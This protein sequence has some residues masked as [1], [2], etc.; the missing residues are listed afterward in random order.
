MIYYTYKITNKVN[1]KFYIGVHKTTDLDDGYMGSGKLLTQAIKKY[2]IENF[3]KEILNTFSSAEEMFDSEAEIVNEN[4]IERRDTYNVKI[5]GSG[6]WDHINNDVEFRKEKNR[7][8][9]HKTHA[10]Y[11]DKYVLWGAKG[12][13]A[14]FRKNGMNPGIT[15]AGK[16]AML[17]KKHTPETIAKMSASSKGTGIGKQNSQYGT[18]WIHNNQVSKTI[19]KDDLDEYLIEGWI[20][21]R[22]MKF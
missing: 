8:A 14:N 20:K 10:L 11:A 1:G 17:G 12:G 16:T 13:R 18:C 7:K 22:K 2:G 21:G 6:G 19:N 9:G 3:E 4:F 5:G 15:L